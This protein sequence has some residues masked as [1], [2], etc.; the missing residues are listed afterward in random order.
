FNATPTTDIYTLPLHDALPIY[1]CLAR[2]RQCIADLAEYVDLQLLVCGI[3]NPHGRRVLVA[4][5]PRDDRFRQPAL[6]AHAVHDLNLVR[7][8]GDRPHDPVVPGSR[9]I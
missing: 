9:F 2:L 3:S 5:Q 6:A 8:A 4:G 1:S 7:A